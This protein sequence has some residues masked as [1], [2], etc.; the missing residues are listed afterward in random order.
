MVVNC[1]KLKAQYESDCLVT[2]KEAAGELFVITRNTTAVTLLERMREG[3]GIASH[4]RPM[5]RIEGMLVDLGELVDEC[6]AFLGDNGNATWF[7]IEDGDG[8]KTVT[9]KVW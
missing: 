8:C 7:P 6:K 2:N 4:E 5:F 9:V 3:L 1:I